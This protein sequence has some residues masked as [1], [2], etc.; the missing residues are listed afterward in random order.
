MQD[1]LETTVGSAAK[2]ANLAEKPLL[3]REEPSET[4]EAETDDGRGEIVE[5]PD[6]K[7]I[8]ATKEGDVTADTAHYNFT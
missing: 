3:A 2:E 6:E 8:Q 7:E 5:P 1:N 4:D